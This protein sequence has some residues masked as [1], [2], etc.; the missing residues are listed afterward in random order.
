MLNFVKGLLTNR[1]GIILATLNLCY[2]VSNIEFMPHHLPS[3][4]TKLF[5]CVNSPALMFSILSNAITQTLCYE[6]FRLNQVDILYVMSMFFITFQWLFIAHLA[7][8]IAQKLSKG[9]L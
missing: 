3:T 5:I 2:F 6:F 1:F 7:R 9:S 4:M 8:I